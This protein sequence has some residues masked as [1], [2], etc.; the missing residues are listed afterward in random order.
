MSI[1]MQPYSFIK[2]SQP[3][4][5]KVNKLA[6]GSNRLH[7]YR[8]G[9]SPFERPMLHPLCHYVSKP[10]LN[11]STVLIIASRRQCKDSHEYRTCNNDTWT[12]AY[13]RGT[14]NVPRTLFCVWP[15][16]SLSRTYIVH[17]HLRT[18]CSGYVALAT[19]CRQPT[20]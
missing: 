6:Q 3:E 13:Y 15:L 1:A 17:T 11:R 5:R 7:R 8:T 10:W 9:I 2:L 20:G 16:R 19:S 12:N 18:V 4:Q 14:D